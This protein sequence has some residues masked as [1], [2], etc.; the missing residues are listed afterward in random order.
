MQPPEKSPADFTAQ[1]SRDAA[2]QRGTKARG[3]ERAS[4][5]SLPVTPALHRILSRHSEISG[6]SR[7]EVAS[8]ILESVLTSTMPGSWRHFDDSSTGNFSG[9]RTKPP[10]GRLKLTVTPEL[11]R[12]L[13][14]LSSASYLTAGEIAALIIEGGPATA[15]AMVP[16]IEAQA[17]LHEQWSQQVGTPVRI[18]AEPQPEPTTAPAR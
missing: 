6:A 14:E 16:A 9:A 3:P 2:R 4:F 10:P 12:R 5:V 11:G 13:G 17:R 8:G 18:I 15:M 7:E 1:T